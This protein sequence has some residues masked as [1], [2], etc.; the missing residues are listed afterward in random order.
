MESES[1]APG[2]L[3]LDDA[4]VSIGAKNLK[5]TLESKDSPQETKAR[6]ELAREDAAHQRTNGSSS[7][8]AP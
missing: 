1:Q 5:F 3:K 8:I 6:L 7:F 4:I 2:H